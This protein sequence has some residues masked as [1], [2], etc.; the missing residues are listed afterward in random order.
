MLCMKENT[1][2]ES[3]S[4]IGRRRTRSSQRP[5]RCGRQCSALA[6]LDAGQRAT[7]TRSMSSSISATTTRARR[8]RHPRLRDPGHSHLPFINPAVSGGEAIK[9]GGRLIS[10]ARLEI[11]AGGT[12]DRFLTLPA[13]LNITYLCKA[14]LFS[15]A[16]RR[17]GEQKLVS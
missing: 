8:V 16:V 3:P 14:R 17:R 11:E 15:K 9:A 13:V 2:T 10:L 5:L 7:S 12:L 1:D 4:R 6:A